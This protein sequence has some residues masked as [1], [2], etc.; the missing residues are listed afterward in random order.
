MN[1]IELE[2]TPEGGIMMLADDAVD[3]RQFGMVE[4]ERASDVEF[5][6]GAQVWE[7][8]SHKTGELIGGGFGTRAEALAFEKTWYSPSGKGWKELTE[9]EVVS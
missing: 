8:R 4:V 2:I 9:K 3:L 6:N 7:V 5:N 1:K